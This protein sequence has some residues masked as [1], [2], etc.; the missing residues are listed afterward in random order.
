MKCEHSNANSPCFPSS[1]TTT[2]TIPLQ[3]FACAAMALTVLIGMFSIDRRSMEVHRP[4]LLFVYF[5]V[6]LC[7]CALLCIV[8]AVSAHDW[9]LAATM[10]DAETPEEVLFTNLHAI[11]PACIVA[12]LNI[13]Q[14]EL[15]MA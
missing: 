6:A 14:R 15:G 12:V 2:D 5:F 4:L 11:T 8:L 9:K 3:L 13:M 10:I 7:D 1:D